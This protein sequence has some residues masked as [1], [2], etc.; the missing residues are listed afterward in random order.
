LRSGVRD[1]LTVSIRSKVER[2]KRS[3]QVTVTKS[4]GPR[5][6]SIFSSSRRAGRASVVFS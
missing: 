6:F 5:A 1:L 2:A 4:Q 3:I